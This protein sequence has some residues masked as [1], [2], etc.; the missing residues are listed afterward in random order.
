MLEHYVHKNQKKLR[1]GYTTGSCAAL[2]AAGAATLLL[3][4]SVP[5][6]MT[7]LTP[8]GIAVTADILDPRLTPDSAS[9]A[10]QKD[11]G[12][13]PDVTNGMLVVATVRRIA[14]HD[15]VVDGGPG[16]GRVTRKGLDQPVGAAAIN[17]VPRRMIAEEVRRMLEQENAAVGL[18]V[19]ISI[20]GGEAVAQKTF[21]PRLGIEGGLSILGTTGIVEPMSEQALVDSIRIELS[22]LQAEGYHSV[23]LTP[24]NYG[25]DFIR[26]TFGALSPLT[27]KCSNYLGET[28]DNAAELGFQQLLLVGHIGK[29]VKLAAGI[30]NTHSRMADG[31]MEIITAHAALCGATR[32]LAAELMQC[33][34]TDEA[35]AALEREA[36]LHPVME[37]IA[38]RALFHLRRRVGAAVRAE[39]VLFSNE[40]GILAESP[41]AGELRQM[42][43]EELS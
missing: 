42:F 9:C 37:S 11:S 19:T 35:L 16:V 8:G 41:G 28:L 2:A 14:G 38:E 6:V 23:V 7:L 18:H 32:P 20:P 4:G 34:T 22:R 30:M 31:R 3:R 15:I 24:G 40:Q 25:T 1:C 13:D 26:R 43:L 12:D 5:P 36:L 33:V 29:L 39:L 21:N 27:I 17:R 10:V